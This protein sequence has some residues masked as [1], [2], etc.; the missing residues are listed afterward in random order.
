MAAI[1][2]T[3]GRRLD[4]NTDSVIVS[5][6]SSELVPIRQD[7]KITVKTEEVRIQNMSRTAAFDLLDQIIA[8]RGELVVIERD[9]VEINMLIDPRISLV[10]QT[11]R[12]SCQLYTITFS[13]EV[14][15]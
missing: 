8:A 2:E 14:V 15:E 7:T 10:P 3:K 11:R 4:I 6:L 13:G 12:D 5:T 9:S 1:A